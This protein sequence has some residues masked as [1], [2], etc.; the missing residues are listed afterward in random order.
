M[1][2]LTNLA[3]NERLQAEGKDGTDYSYKSLWR[4]C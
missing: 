4:P 2:P 1:M 3:V